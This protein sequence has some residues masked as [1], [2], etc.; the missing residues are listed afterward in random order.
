MIKTCL[1]LRSS[2]GYTPRMP[3]KRKSVEPLDAPRRSLRIKHQENTELSKKKR[4]KST[5]RSEKTQ[6]GLLAVSTTVKS[7]IRQSRINKTIDNSTKIDKKKGFTSTS[8]TN[9][10]R[11]IFKP[12]QLGDTLPDI[13]LK[14]EL[15]EDAIKIFLSIS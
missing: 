3:L 2:C 1:I 5:Q 7:S 13:I 9:P 4:F 15:G 6:D 11:R 10:Q 14:N 12:I 8:P